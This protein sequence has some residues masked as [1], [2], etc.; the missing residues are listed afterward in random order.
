MPSTRRSCC[1]TAAGCGESRA[2]W[3]AG[4]ATHPPTT[5]GCARRS[6]FTAARRWRSMMPPSRRRTGRRDAQPLLPTAAATSCRAA[7]GGRS[8]RLP[9]ADSRRGNDGPRLTGQDGAVLLARRWLGS[10]DGGP[11][12]SGPGVLA[13]G[14]VRPS[15]GAGRRDGRLAARCRLA[16]AGR[17][18]GPAVPDALA[19]PLL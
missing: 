18:L 4:G 10:W 14:P 3:C 12:Q 1:S 7:A 17:P 13:R 19:G 16:R 6:W 9:A 11:A 5:S 2:T 8:G 15:V